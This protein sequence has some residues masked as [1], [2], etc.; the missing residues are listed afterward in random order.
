MEKGAE[1]PQDRYRIKQKEGEYREE[2]AGWAS[3]SE[4]LGIPDSDAAE[5][6]KRAEARAFLGAML[7]KLK[8]RQRTVL[9]MHYLEGLTLQEVADSIHVT[10]GR[11]GQIE[12]DSLRNLRIIIAKNE[13][14][15]I[16][17][18]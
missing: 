17:S 18:R 1:R 2:E 15:G 3:L 10:D 4:A 16:A 11:A 8:K 7:P 6:L 9:E 13:R 14:K 5:E 12:R